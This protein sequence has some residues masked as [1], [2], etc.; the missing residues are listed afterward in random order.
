M[1]DDVESS[2]LLRLVAIIFGL[3]T[4]FFHFH[5]LS[6]QKCAMHRGMRKPHGL[7]VRRYVARL[8]DLKEYL[9]SLPGKNLTLKI[10][11]MELN[12]RVLNS[13]LLLFFFWSGLCDPIAFSV[14]V[15]GYSI[16]EQ[17]L[18]GP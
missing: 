5:A 4:H 6:K 8:I 3:G 2:T 17:W 14:L 13:I 11:I 10:G 7:K 1:S 12:E 15:G 16:P 18:Q 9:A